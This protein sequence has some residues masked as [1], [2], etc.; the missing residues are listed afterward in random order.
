MAGWIVALVVLGALVAVPYVFLMR[1]DVDQA[2]QGLGA[3]AQ[4]NDAQAETLLMNAAQ[5]AT[6]FFAEQGSM[7]GY[8]PTQAF[9]FDPQTPFDTSSTAAPG[10][11]SIRGADATSAV[12]VTKGGSGPLCVGLTAGLLTFG[13]VDAANAAQCPGAAWS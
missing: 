13:R 4:A 1:S 5:A 2:K 3:V 8:G 6:V 7:A 10:R 11:V 9:A 12:F